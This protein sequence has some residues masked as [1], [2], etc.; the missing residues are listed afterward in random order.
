M[1]SEGRRDGFVIEFDEEVLVIEGE[2]DGVDLVLRYPSIPGMG[3][4]D[5]VGRLILVSD[6]EEY[7][8]AY[9]GFGMT[10]EILEMVGELPYRVEEY[11]EEQRRRWVV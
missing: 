8:V 5:E 1:L 2:E 11:S 4:F 10:T 3:P 9:I 6:G 7:P